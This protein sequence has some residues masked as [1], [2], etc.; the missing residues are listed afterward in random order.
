MR[1]HATFYPRQKKVTRDFEKGLLGC[2][3]YTIRMTYI[4]RVVVHVRQDCYTYIKTRHMNIKAHIYRL[5][6]AT[7]TSKITSRATATATT[8]TTTTTTTAGSTST[9]KTYS[10]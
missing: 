5:N 6:D 7:L 8:T 10:R 1:V 9:I 3:I 2:A 4:Y